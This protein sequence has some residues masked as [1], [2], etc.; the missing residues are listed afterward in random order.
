MWEKKKERKQGR[1]KDGTSRS[2]DC[3]SG[4]GQD[5]PSSAVTRVNCRKWGGACRQGWRSGAILCS[6]TSDFCCLEV[7]CEC[8]YLARWCRL[9]VCVRERDRETERDRAHKQ[10][11]SAVLTPCCCDR[12]KDRSRRLGGG[13]EG[14]ATG[15][16]LGWPWQT[17]PARLI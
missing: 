12:N 2:T 7:G 4:T 3:A 1:A 10:Y 5:L 14:V 8:E 11:F 15:A 16:G 6:R 9:C 13:W 17:S